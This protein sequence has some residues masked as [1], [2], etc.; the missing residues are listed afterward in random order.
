MD[1]AAESSTSHPT[2]LWTLGDSRGQCQLM[3]QVSLFFSDP[4]L[5]SVFAVGFSVCLLT[6]DYTLG[7]MADDAL[8]TSVKSILFVCGSNKS[9][10]A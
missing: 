8:S 9:M 4:C 5:Y 6:V 2:S 1:C 10:Y 3:S 7:C